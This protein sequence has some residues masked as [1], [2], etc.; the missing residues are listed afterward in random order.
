MD[1]NSLG[2]Q[3]ILN[4]ASA[5]IFITLVFIVAWRRQRIDLIDSAWGVIF[6]VITAVT[7]A[8]S[9][10]R[11]WPG[12]IAAGLTVVWGA[13]L[14]THIFRRFLASSQQDKRYTE[15]MSTWPH[16]LLAL[17]TYTRIYLVQALSATIITVP[18]VIA[19][20]NEHYSVV[21]VLTGGALW[22]IGFVFEVVADRQLRSFLS[23]PANRGHIMTQ[24]LWRYSR[25]P[26]YF[27]EMTMWWGIFVLTLGMNQWLVGII[28][29][30]LITCL[31]C[32]VSGIPPAE[33]GAQRRWGGDPTYQ[34]Y[35]RRTSV[36]IPL[37][38]KKS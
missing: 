20:R 32:F 5:T 8:A 1:V 10:S 2:Q 14:A 3:L 7:L 21:A 30:L 16:R 24:G 31:L 37:P 34:S 15:L 18:V 19:I 6:I 13:R 9:H 36:L 17:Q 4:A 23:Q 35:R 25:H 29:P 11:S 12:W 26:N 28:G 33:R 38:P 27:G 22:L